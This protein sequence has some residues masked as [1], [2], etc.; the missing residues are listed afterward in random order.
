MLLDQLWPSCLP[1]VQRNWKGRL[2]PA[3]AGAQATGIANDAMETLEFHVEDDCSFKEVQEKR[4]E[5]RNLLLQ[6]R[7]SEVIVFKCPSH[8]MPSLC[9]G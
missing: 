5:M 1:E 8:F 3:A 6:A 7:I 9:L 4:M 2:F